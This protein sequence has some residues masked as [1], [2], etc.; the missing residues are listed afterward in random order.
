MKAPQRGSRIPGRRS[1]RRRG[2]RRSRRRGR[3]AIVEVRAGRRARSCGHPSRSARSPRPAACARR[4]LPAARFPASPGQRWGRKEGRAVER[5]PGKWGAGRAGRG[6]QLGR[7]PPPSRSAA[8]RRASG[9]GLPGRAPHPRPGSCLGQWE[10]AE[11]EEEPPWR[12]SHRR[13]KWGRRVRLGL[14]RAEHTSVRA[15]Y[16][17]LSQERGSRIEAPNPQS[18]GQRQR[19]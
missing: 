2:R 12:L 5:P 7:P 3:E 6:Q 4:N 10:E 13:R 8:Q 14:G 1:R 16:H 11:Q 15:G 19:S 9:S 18:P 17:L